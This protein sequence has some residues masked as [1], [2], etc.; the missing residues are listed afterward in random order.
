VLT[1]QVILNGIMLGGIYA[2]MAIGFSVIWGVMNII[3]LAHGSMIIMG[4]YLTYFMAT[5]MGMD[6]FLTVPV[7]AVALFAF[8]YLLQRYLINR[9]IEASVFMTMIMTFGLDMV[10][11][12][13]H[14]SLFTADIRSLST[15]Y[16]GMGFEVAGVRVA[17]TRLAVFAIAVL[18]TVAL[19]VFMN[20]T[21]VGNAIKATSFDLEAAQLVG[22]DTKQIYAITFG[23]GAA[24]AGITGSLLAVVFSFS[25]VGGVTLTMKSFVVVILGGL[26]S[27]PGAIVGGMVLGVAENLTSI[28]LRPGYVNIVGFGLLLLV[29]IVRP[30]GLFGKRFY[31]EI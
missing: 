28:V 20:R 29:L 4:S 19:L 26:G 23:I 2:C 12:N 13:A 6:P 18:L 8:G 27:I 22:V 1:T 24:M 3:N 21:R 17:Y 16:G 9:V 10:I 5:G 11:V 25:P 30:R 14:I 7:A 31:A 15:G